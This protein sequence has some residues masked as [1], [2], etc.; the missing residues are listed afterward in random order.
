MR[1][2]SEDRFSV[3]LVSTTRPGYISFFLSFLE[4]GGEILRV[5]GNFLTR[6]RVN[7][8]HHRSVAHLHQGLEVVHKEHHLEPS[9]SVENV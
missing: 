4:S 5:L 3:R 8:R 2:D 6:S 1:T 9:P 7:R